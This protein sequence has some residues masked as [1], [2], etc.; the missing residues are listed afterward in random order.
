MVLA[1]KSILSNIFW[2]AVFWCGLFIIILMCRPLWAED[3]PCQDDGFAG[4]VIGDRPD[5]QVVVSDANIYAA[6]YS[7]TQYFFEF[8]P[9]YHRLIVPLSSIV[10]ANFSPATCSYEAEYDDDIFTNGLEG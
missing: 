1:M 9:D 8:L 10:N 4:Q 2:T 5:G 6:S 7:D 3:Y